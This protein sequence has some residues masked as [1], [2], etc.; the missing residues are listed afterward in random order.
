MLMFKCFSYSLG[1]GVDE[2]S[3]KL[4]GG[5]YLKEGAYYGGP[6]AGPLHHVH[7]DSESA[8]SHADLCIL[9]IALYKDSVLCW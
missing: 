8:C 4:T 6:L 5:P 7:L 9:A 2:M 3:G 1:V